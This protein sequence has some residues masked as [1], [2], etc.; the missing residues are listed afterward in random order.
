MARHSARSGPARPARPA[1]QWRAGASVR[2]ATGNGDQVARSE[3]MAG[4]VHGSRSLPPR[5]PDCDAFRERVKI[6]AFP[7]EFR[8]REIMVHPSAG[9]TARRNLTKK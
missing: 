5:L 9:D 8:T 4:R 2:L 7:L 3:S 6:I 1:R